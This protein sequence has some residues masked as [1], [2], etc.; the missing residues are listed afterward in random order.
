MK[1]KDRCSHI[2]GESVFPLSEGTV[3]TCLLYAYLNYY[4]S[5]VLA[6]STAFASASGIPAAFFP[7]A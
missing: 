5:C 1:I 4:A 6:I 3:N 2:P 7:P